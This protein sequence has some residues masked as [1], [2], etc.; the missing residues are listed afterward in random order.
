M[1]VGNAVV[2]GAAMF[3][4]HD[5][6]GFFG[7]DGDAQ[8]SREAI[9]RT[10][11]DDPE[12]GG[13]IDE[14]ACRLVDRAVAPCDDH[15]LVPFFDCFPC[16]LGGVQGVA[17]NTNDKV[18]LFLIDSHGDLFGNVFLRFVSRYRVDDKA[19]FLFCHETSM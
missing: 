8:V 6:E 1:P 5:F 15:A 12:G 2:D 16:N 10:Q 17:G 3:T 9:A 18:V 4:Q 19:H 11:R 7:I 13:G 14:F